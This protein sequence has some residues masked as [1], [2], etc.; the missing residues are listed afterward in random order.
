MDKQLSCMV[1]IETL[2]M[3]GSSA[4][5][6]LGAVIFDQDDPEENYIGEWDVSYDWKTQL[7]N[8]RTKE[9]GAVEWWKKQDPKVQEKQFTGE[10]DLAGGLLQFQMWLDSFEEI[11][12][13]YYWNSNFDQ[14]ILSDASRWANVNL[15]LVDS[16]WKTMCI[17]SIGRQI[18]RASG[19]KW[20]LNNLK[21]KAEKKYLGAHDALSDCKIQV[22][23]M[24]DLLV[25]E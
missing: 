13:Y 10:V 22:E 7:K 6:S 24:K 1:D 23:V 8:G 25:R 15:D 20:L 19:N 21:K 11:E 3:A 5:L 16:Y 9:S 17:A 18:S 12:Y 4:I 2:G 14:P